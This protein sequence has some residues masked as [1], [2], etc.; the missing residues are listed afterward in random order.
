MRNLVSLISLILAS[1]LALAADPSS[2]EKDSERV[3]R[4]VATLEKNPLGVEAAQSRK[5]LMQWLEETK[6]FSITVCEIL[7]P[8]PSQ[9]PP[10][11][12]VLLAQ[13]MFGNLAYQIQNP[14][15]RDQLS[16][17]VAGVESTLKAY[18]VFVSKDPK[19]RIAHFDDLLQAQK[20]GSLHSRMA[21]VIAKECG[22]N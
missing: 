9:S 6:D 2:P 21:P 20:S 15:I 17:Q 11:S 16:L 8:V 12:A 10:N 7:G 19:S 4:L 5:W 3:V 1:G 18:A 13:Q 22:G 14:G